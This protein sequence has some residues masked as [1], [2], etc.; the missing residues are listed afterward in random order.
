MA[1]S[2]KGH[3]RLTRESIRSGW[4]AGA[5]S[6]W[7]L[8]I[9]LLSHADSTGACF[10]G[11][12]LLRCECAFGDGQVSRRT[13]SR[14]R[15]ELVALG[16]VKNMDQ[17]GGT[18]SVHYVIALPGTPLTPR[19][20]VSTVDKVVHPRVDRCGVT[21]RTDVSTKVVQEKKSK[22]R[23]TP[24]PLEGDDQTSLN[25]IES[26]QK[27]DT[28]SKKYEYDPDY[29][30]F[31]EGYPRKAGKRAGE[32]AYKAWRRKRV[33]SDAQGL[34]KLLAPYI[35][36]WD[37][38]TEDFVPHPG[39]W[40]NTM[41]WDQEPPKPPG[42]SQSES[43][44][45]KELRDYDILE[46]PADMIDP[47]TDAIVRDLIR[48]PAKNS[49]AM[50]PHVYRSNIEPMRG[51]GRTDGGAIIIALPQIHQ[52]FTAKR[53]YSDHITDVLGH[54]PVFTDVLAAMKRKADGDA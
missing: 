42:S 12:D 29:L 16:Y 8:Y 9:A 49:P 39:S 53:E 41:P 5:G 18:N 25:G 38:R 46:V 48:E 22:G 43:T 4:Y 37:G 11:T 7:P 21:P 3:V 13:L 30:I 1:D 40:I 31:Y 51:I 36:A 10:P 17:P 27:P 15:R 44:K 26:S 23:S 52:M 50:K 19:T 32:K 24:H 20:G 45:P 47:E 33:Y 2:E 34:L 14:W 35:V 54:E 6:A 28:K